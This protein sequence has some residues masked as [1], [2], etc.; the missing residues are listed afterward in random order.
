MHPGHWY[1][2]RVGL[3][4]KA[5]RS[6]MQRTVPAALH[7][8][9]YLMQVIKRKTGMAVAAGP[10]ATMKLPD[11][12]LG[13]SFPPAAI[14]DIYKPAASVF[15]P[16]VLGIYE[17]ELHS[18]IESVCAG[19]FARI[20]DIGAA[21]GYYAVGLA[22]R[23]PTA[24]VIAFEGDAYGQMRLRRTAQLNGVLDSIEILGRCEQGDLRQ[25]LGGSSS[26]FILCDVEGYEEVLLDPAGVPEL[27]SASILVELHEA[28]VPGIEV[29]MR[30]RFAG[31]H[32]IVAIEQERR[33][34]REY[35]F[36]TVLTYFIPNKYRAFVVNERRGDGM[37]WL[38]MTPLAR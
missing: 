27:K 9:I 26:T 13:F 23:C 36:W 2:R 1:R 6:F 31:T 24:R 32:S 17:R 11:A 5:S 8:V 21:D 10:F 38:W 4:Q 3:V 20:I 35:P 16:K 29:L 14:V 33:H 19:D 18:A 15:A 28:N 22:K 12:E 34:W 30:G 7:P 25:A 37:V